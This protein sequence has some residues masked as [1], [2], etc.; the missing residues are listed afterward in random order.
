MKV[1]LIKDC[2]ECPLSEI[3]GMVVKCCSGKWVKPREVGKLDKVVDKKTIP[4]WCPLED[5]EDL[6]KIIEER[7]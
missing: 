4:Q 6:I 1:I 3:D 2:A 7:R 5:A